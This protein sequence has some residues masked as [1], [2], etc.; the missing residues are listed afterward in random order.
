MKNSTNFNKYTTVD[1]KHRSTYFHKCTTVDGKDLQNFIKSFAR[2]K[3]QTNNTM[4]VNGTLKLNNKT[5]N[6]KNMYTY[7]R[8]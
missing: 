6:G 8:Q 1:G 2:K 3:S 7:C 4:W 5:F